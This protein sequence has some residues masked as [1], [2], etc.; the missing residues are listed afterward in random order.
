MSRILTR[1]GQ[2]QY[3]AVNQ[4]TAYHDTLSSL[5]IRYPKIILDNRKFDENRKYRNSVL[6]ERD[7]ERYSKLGVCRTK[8]HGCD[9]LPD[10]EFVGVSDLVNVLIEAGTHDG[11]SVPIPQA[12]LQQVSERIM[13]DADLLSIHDLVTIMSVMYENDFMHFG[14]INK[15]KNELIFDIEKVNSLQIGIFLNSITIGWNIVSPKLIIA[16]SRRMDTL[17]A[18]DGE[19][20]EYILRS[21]LKCPISILKRKDIIKS[22][23]QMITAISEKENLSL[24]EVTVVLKDLINVSKKT[25]LKISGIH[26]LIKMMNREITD[27]ESASNALWILAEL[28]REHM[29]SVDDDSF[30]N[31]LETSLLSYC[32]AIIDT[33]TSLSRNRKNIDNIKLRND[34][35]DIASRIITASN[36]LGN[37]KLIDAYL[38]ALTDDSVH[39]L[40]CH[41]LVDLFLMRREDIRIV[42]QPEI[43]RKWNSFSQRQRDILA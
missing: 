25:G 28:H 1:Q 35:V 14:L 16:L 9:N 13:K 40:R 27:V 19:G 15:I 31:Q 18:A 43:E 11:K 2:R 42:I 30:K 24:A 39:G 26:K 34:A 7:I 12:F 8:N 36:K 38:P 33:C 3:K 17:I 41:S 6:K 20:I 4:S 10:Y 21:F 37:E 29:T 5:D 22:I 23:E 32:G